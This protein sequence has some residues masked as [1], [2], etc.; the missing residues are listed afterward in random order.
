MGLQN[1]PKKSKAVYNSF[2]LPR[3]LFFFTPLTNY[4]DLFIT[5]TLGC[6]ACLIVYKRK[7]KTET[8]LKVDV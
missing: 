3:S 1:S 4:K 7:M 5:H 6:I 2:I 8:I